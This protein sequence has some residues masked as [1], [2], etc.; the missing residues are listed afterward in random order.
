MRWIKII[1]ALA[2]GLAL[3]GCGGGGGDPGSRLNSS[4]TA[5][6]N[7]TSASGTGTGSSSAPPTL[8]AVPT[9]SL[10]L[11]NASKTV[12]ADNT[13]LRSSTFYMR[14]LLRDGSGQPVP[15]VL[16]KF[17]ADAV[18]ASLLS[19]STLTDA[20][21]YALVAIQS[22][23]LKAVAGTVSATATIG[24]QIVSNTLNI[25]TNSALIT[26][27]SLSIPSLSNG[28]NL[29]ANQAREVLA[30]VL[31]D[32]NP[33]PA[34]LVSAKF[35][36][37]CGAFSADTVASNSSGELRTTYTA[38]GACTAATI[39][40]SLVEVANQAKS[41]SV[42]VEAA[43]SSAIVFV[44]ATTPT[45][46]SSR[47]GG[48]LSVSTLTFKLVDSGNVGIAGKELEARLAAES[49]A[50]G[51]RLAGNQVSTRLFTDGAGFIRVVVYAGAVPGAVTVRVV[52]INSP[53]I[54]GVSLGVSVT[55]GKAVQDR[56]SLGSDKA[57]LEA[58][59]ANDVTATLTFSA[60]DRFG[61]PVPAG[62]AVNFATNAGVIVGTSG[63]TC[64]LDSASQCAVT[65]RS[66]TGS[67]RPPNG[68]VFVLAWIS[69]EESFTDRNG[70]GI[71]Q[72]GEPFEALGK[73]Y[74]DSDWSGA[75]TVGEQAI[76]TISPGTSTC[77]ATAYPSVANTCDTSVWRDDTL[78]RAHRFLV[79]ASSVASITQVGPRS[80]DGFWVWISDDNKHPSLALS[81]T[82][83]AKGGVFEPVTTSDTLTLAD[84]L[85]QAGYSPLPALFNNSMPTGSAIWAL[86]DTASAQCKVQGLSRDTVA[87]DQL[88]GTLV[89]VRL[90]GQDDCA[91]VK[92][93]VTV[94]SP[95]GDATVVRF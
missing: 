6:S 72:A 32:G 67:S 59:N 38:G 64:Q 44:G 13:L 55:S 19:P 3:L 83:R 28:G 26:L 52:D 80:G 63:A 35:S 15:N 62:T 14:A 93:A 2:L 76:G 65:Y 21:G 74:V 23:S 29:P 24:T 60:A 20:S 87:R 42:V 50:A 45:M 37:T 78:V 47:V 71:W 88:G 39:T 8:T 61:N 41:I 17:T 10:S 66:L 46:V 77:P 4:S 86:V 54:T 51:V 7:A 25:Q 95:K 33:A 69:G 75:F 1:S 91:T 48:A 49:Q 84:L 82:Q 68:H 43:S 22:T 5:G 81:S 58:L 40:A 31:V 79:L 94:K 89:F 16:V 85:G 36:S 57:S 18:V 56:V 30:T 34:S 11:L 12:V 90:G 53:S 70:D 27:R 9:L 92:V 73:P